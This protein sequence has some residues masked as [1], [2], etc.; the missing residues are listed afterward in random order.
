M[1]VSAVQF[2]V[3]VHSSNGIVCI[4]ISNT[5]MAFTSITEHV[6][7]G[8]GRNTDVTDQQSQEDNE[9]DMASGGIHV[10]FDRPAVRMFCGS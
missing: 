6:C 8:M 4:T 1:R 9:A 10:W 3:L 7:R 5:E 2:A